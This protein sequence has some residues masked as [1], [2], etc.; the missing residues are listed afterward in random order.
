MIFVD[1]Y[2]SWCGPCKKLATQIF[3]Q[4]KVGDY[5]NERFVN[6]K[7]DVEKGE[8]LAFEKL[9]PG[10]IKLYPTMLILNTKGKLIHKIAGTRP[11]DELIA[12]IEAGLQGTTIYTLEKE[13]N[14]GRRDWEFTRDYLTLL[15]KAAERKQYEKVVRAYIAP[16]PIDTLLNAEIWAKAGK[17][18]VKEPYSKEFRFAVEHLDEL[19]ARGLIDRYRLEAQMNDEL[20]FAVNMV[21]IASNEKRSRDSVILLQKRAEHLKELLKNPVK[22]FPQSLAE[23]SLTECKLHDDADRL[24]ER[25]C[26]LVECG[27]A[28]R[29]IF[30]AGMLKYLAEHLE[31]PVRLRHCAELARQLKARYPQTDWIQDSFNEIIKIV[32]NR[33]K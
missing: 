11:A 22:G 12:D 17:I 10:E 31:D 3:P 7:Y 28:E 32:D 30:L 19:E 6:V 26:V 2:T 13:F 20:G 23:L 29:D 18:I 16:L 27:F 21:Y 24:Y 5:L 14:A 15:E 1:C 33:V 25:F 4:E 8:G 9:Y